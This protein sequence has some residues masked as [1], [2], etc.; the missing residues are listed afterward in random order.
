MKEEQQSS[1]TKS[2]LIDKSIKGV[3]WTLLDVLVNKIGF[4][5]ATLYIARLLG[6]KVFALIGMITVFITIGNSLVD[7]GMSVSLVRTPK[8]TQQ[9]ISSV[10]LGNLSI[11][12]IVYL[13]FYLLA[14]Y[15]S[16]FYSQ[17]ILTDVVR[18]YCIIFIVSALR[19][20]QSA[21]L[22]RSLD[23]KKNTLITIPA[24][25]VA[26]LI[27]IIFAHKGFGIWS[28]IA[29]YLT[30]Q[31]VITALLWT[32][33]NTKI[34]GKFSLDTLKTHL[35][36]GYKLTISGLLNT[37]CTNINNILIGRFYPIEQSGY[38]ERA[39]SLNMYPSTVFTAIIS[40]VS[41]PALSKIQDDKEK[42]TN[43]LSFLIKYSFI[44]MSF[45]MLMM[46]YFAHEIIALLLGDQWLPAVPH[47]RIIS[48]ASIFLPI[49]MFNVNTLQVYGRSDYFLKAELVKKAIQLLAIIILFKFGILWLI[50]SLVILSTS[51]LL[52]NSH[53]VG[54]IINFG[55]IHQLKTIRTPLMIF[56]SLLL[57]A[58]VITNSNLGIDNNIFIQISFLLL[59]STT[60]TIYLVRHNKKQIHSIWSL[61]KK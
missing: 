34:N 18:I 11:S 52:V 16:D 61:I 56:V 58:L 13:L 47:L 24:V 4:F 17:P 45:L 55:F 22:T 1:I 28:V 2:N 9:D 51:E 48:I 20:V 7:S 53:F 39:Y 33:S 41:M 37:A 46:F 54:K 19:A 25:I 8:I 14:P 44:A 21:L 23:F 57:I 26:I 60:Y 36:F 49:H 59:A 40:K 43:T 12:I 27:G 38:Y 6:P 42:T 5:I 30:Q 15:I 35:N 31:T 29:M 32:F 50:S 3:Y 10:F